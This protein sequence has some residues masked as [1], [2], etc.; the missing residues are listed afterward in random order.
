MGVPILEEYGFKSSVAVIYDTVGTTDKS[1]LAQLQ[2]YVAKGNE[3]IPHGPNDGSGGSG[4]LFTA[5]TT[6]AQRIADVNACRDYLIANKLCGP[7]GAKSYI[8]PQ[9]RYCEST[10]DYSFLQ[11]MRDNGYTVGRSANAPTVVYMQKNNGLSSANNAILAGPIIGHTWTSAPTEAANIATINARI[12][13]T[14]AN[15]GDCTLMLHRIVGVDAAAQ[16][17]EISTNRLRQICDAI[18]AEVDAGNMEVV[19]YSEFA[20]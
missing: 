5:W 20:K 18:K 6:N 9:G 13:A 2:S 1:T 19:L 3:C 16:S 12:A 14:A 8:W 10:S 7:Y 11:L 17:T 4:N 15:G